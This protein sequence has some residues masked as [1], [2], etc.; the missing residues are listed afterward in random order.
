MRGASH[1]R[2]FARPAQ[3][4]LRRCT[5]PPRIPPRPAVERPELLS[6]ACTKFPGKVAVGIDARGGRVAVKGW[7]EDGGMEAKVLA[8]RAADAGAAAAGSDKGRYRH[9]GAL[10]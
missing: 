4:F 2:N 6:E 8:L 1:A 7:A 10:S 5:L 9:Q 3:C